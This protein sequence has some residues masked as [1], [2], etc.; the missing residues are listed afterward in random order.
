MIPT[1]MNDH[2]RP[3]TIRATPIR[4]RRCRISTQSPI[5]ATAT[6]TSSLVRTLRVAKTP[7]RTGRSASTA[8]MHH[9]SSGVASVTGWKSKSTDHCSGVYSRYAA[10]HI[11]DTRQSPIHRRAMPYAGNAPVATISGCATSNSF[12]V[13]KTHQKGTNATRIGST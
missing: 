3:P 8:Q 6:P 7:T 10:A 2:S 4:V 1:A 5:P 11:A 13:G 9:S 12:G